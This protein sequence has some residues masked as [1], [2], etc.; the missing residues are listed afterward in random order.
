MDPISSVLADAFDLPRTDLYNY[1]S[2][3]DFLAFTHRE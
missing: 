3:A 1:L 2:E